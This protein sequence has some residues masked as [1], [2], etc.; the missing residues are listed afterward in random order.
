[1]KEGQ[2]TLPTKSIVFFRVH[3]IVNSGENCYKY[4]NNKVD[5]LI[6]SE[7]NIDLKLKTNY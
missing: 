1:M 3:S 5:N 6:L 2:C 4:E 7:N